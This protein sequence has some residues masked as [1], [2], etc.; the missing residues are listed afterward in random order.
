MLY[1]RNGLLLPKIYQ[2]RNLASLEILV[3]FLHCE[4]GADF[5]P[6]PKRP[7]L[8]DFRS[9]GRTAASADGSAQRE[10]ADE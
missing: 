10:A 3:N 4:S 5:N 8:L 1:R 9:S 7:G 2:R 6:N